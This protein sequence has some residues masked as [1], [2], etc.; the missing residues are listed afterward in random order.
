MDTR[1]G[2]RMTKQNIGYAD[3]RYIEGNTVRKLDTVK[4]MQQ[5]PRKG[6]RGIHDG[7]ESG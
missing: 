6:R 3:R 1:H 7:K 4:E 5:K 2:R